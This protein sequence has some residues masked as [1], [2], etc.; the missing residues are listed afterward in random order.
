MNI[1][2]LI[3]DWAWRVNNG[4][5]DPKNRNHIQVLEAVLKAHK[6]P[7]EFIDG[8]LKN[9]TEA[10]VDSETPVKYK[11][12]NGERKEMAFATALKQSDGHPARIEAEKMKDEDPEDTAAASKSMYDNPEPGSDAAKEKETSQTKKSDNL[13]VELKPKQPKKVTKM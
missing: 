6:Y 2:A 12:E 11:D 5:P 4:M 3:R 9:L 1:N 8:Y 13:Q 7:Q 10:E